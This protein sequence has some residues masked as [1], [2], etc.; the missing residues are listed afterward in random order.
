MIKA[1]S[2]YVSLWVGVLV[3]FCALCGAL[4]WLLLSYAA[5]SIH[6]CAHYLAAK[7]LRIACRGL[8]LQPFGITLRLKDNRITE[9]CDEIILC[10]AGPVA[11]LCAAACIYFGCGMAGDGVRYLLFSNLSLAAI[12]L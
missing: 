12:N 8:V 9:P 5:L 11:N 3:L 6:E 7:R 1:G 4:E 2:F 10:L